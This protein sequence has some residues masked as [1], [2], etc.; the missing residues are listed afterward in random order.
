MMPHIVWTAVPTRGRVRVHALLHALI[1]V[2]S[3]FVWR[4]IYGVI[5][6]RSE[7]TRNTTEREE[8]PMNIKHIVLIALAALALG[9]ASVGVAAP[10]IAGGLSGGVVAGSKPG[11]AG[12]Q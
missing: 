8:T 9:L 11:I 5:P 4:R 7:R 2:Q 10:S 1:G 12:G 3:A 6:P